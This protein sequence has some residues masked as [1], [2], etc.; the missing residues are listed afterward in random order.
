MKISTKPLCYGFIQAAACGKPA[1]A[2]KAGG[3]DKAAADGI[4]GQRVDGARL[5]HVVSEITLMPTR[6]DLRVRYVTWAVG[7]AKAMFSCE[8]GTDKKRMLFLFH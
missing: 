4:T 7:R 6:D 8:N 1:V 5:E 3:M 2:G